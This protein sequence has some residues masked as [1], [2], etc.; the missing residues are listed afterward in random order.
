MTTKAKILLGIFSAL[1]V[2]IVIFAPKVSSQALGATTFITQQGGTGTTSPSGIL[3]G[4]NGSTSHLNTVT[5]GNGLSFSGGTLSASGA[6][7]WTPQTWG[8]STSTPIGF[9]NAS[10]GII[11][12][13]SSTFS[14][15]TSGLV[16]NNS[17]R[18]YSF[19][20]SSL[21]GYTP[22]NPTRNITVAGTAN[23]ITSSA[24]AQDLSA[25]RTWT[26][27]LPTRVVFPLS[28]EA[29]YGTTTYASSTVLT[30]GTLYDSGLTTGLVG[31]NNG[32]LY[33]FA[34][35]T[36]NTSQLT[37]DAGFLTAVTA[38]APLSGSGT[39]A[40]HLV[41]SQANTST[42]GY[43]SSSDWNKFNNKWDLASTTIAVPYGGTGSTTLTGILKGAGTSAIATAVNGTDYTLLTTTTCTAGDFVSAL[44][45]S[46]GVTCTTPSG[47][48]YYW[49]FTPST[50]FGVAVQSTTTPEWFQ[51]GLMASTTSYFAN[52][53]T[54]LL[55]V[56]AGEF[57]TVGYPLKVTSSGTGS[58]GSFID[59]YYNSSSPA[60]N[61]YVGG[62]DIYGNSSSA[63]EVY[64]GGINLVMD[65]V[66]TGSEL[67]HLDFAQ[68]DG[69]GGRHHIITPHLTGVFALGSY[70]TGFLNGSIPFGSAG[71]LATSSALT[72]DGTRLNA[73]YASTTALTVSGT[74]YIGSGT[75]L[76]LTTSGTVSNYAGTSCTNQFVRSLSASGVATCATV[77]STDVSLA[78]LTAT[79]ATLTFSGTYNGS[80]ARTIGLN[81]GNANTWTA[82]QQFSNASSTILSA[83][84][85]Y[86]GA[87]ATTTITSAGRV[88]MGTTSPFA[89]ISI[90]AGAGETPFA[91]G[92][93]TSTVFSILSSGKTFVKDL[94]NGWSGVV[95]P[96]RSFVLST[97]TTTGWTASTTASAYTPT[98]TMPF[99]GTLRQ[100]RCTPYVNGTPGSFL[101]VNV[102][103]AGS[104]VT[105][106]YF[107]ASSTIGAEK[108]TAGNTFTAGQRITADFGTTTTAT[109]TNVDC[110][111]DVTETP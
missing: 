22:L 67:A 29:T 43:L 24:G 20:S 11:V 78:N 99:A 70:S 55:S 52:A 95:S 41:I 8:N 80:T 104:N 7:A 36:I 57:G 63:T 60:I 77:A 17:G 51:N 97:A 108:F 96:T 69:A 23:Q 64:M 76:L 19:A 73:T 89:N 102:Q 83:Y 30:A 9:L 94:I 106:S 2:G 111:F 72:F 50:N 107:I 62:W 27:S 82:L 93:T 38:D 35:S 65:G 105:P 92:S 6:F 5:V 58:N 84:S 53:S 21:F 42:N 34:T 25:D 40:S 101:G 54:S 109:A 16:G 91:I 61:D 56:K 12:T 45:A 28:F 1:A 100:V 31:N 88:G 13:A 37:N 33:S 90:N 44:T 86:F 32:L 71:L 4:D 110:T 26:L 81:L 15:L 68:S 39:S 18:L 14:Y 48:T 47:S 46:G 66:T 85:A 103:I 87:T 59:T 79:D 10:N 74:A 3:Y 49:P 98:I 75:G